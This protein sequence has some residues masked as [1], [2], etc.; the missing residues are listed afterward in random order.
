MTHQQQTSFEN[1]VGKGEIARNEQFLLFPQRFLLDQIILYPF[2]HIFDIISLFAAELQKPK[3][4]ISG[5]GLIFFLLFSFQT[6]HSR[7]TTK[8][9]FGHSTIVASHDE[10]MTFMLIVTVCVLFLCSVADGR[11]RVDIERLI[12]DKQV[13]YNM[14]VLPSANQSEPLLIRLA[15]ELKA[16][17]EFEEVNEQLSVIGTLLMGWN[18]ERMTWIPAEYGNTMHF[19]VT[20]ELFW[21]PTVILTNAYEEYQKIGDESYWPI[22]FAYNGDA[23][24][25]PGHVFTTICSADVKFYPW[26][27]QECSL[28][29]QVWGHFVSEVALQPSRD[30]V[31]INHYNGHGTWDFEG[32]KAFLKD[33]NLTISFTLLLNRK[34]TFV[35]VN[36]ILPIIFMGYLNT[37]VFLM[38]T[39]CGERTSYAITVLLALAVFLTLVGD[40]MPKSAR[41]IAY[42]SY[43]IMAVLVLSVIIILEIT[44]TMRVFYHSEGEDIPAH[45]AFLARFL[46]CKTCRKKSPTRPHHSVTGPTGE[47]SHCENIE[48]IRLHTI[49]GDSFTDMSSQQNGIPYW[50]GGYSAN[51]R[52]KDC[53]KNVVSW[54][55]V[56]YALDKIFFVTSF[57]AITVFTTLFLSMTIN[58]KVVL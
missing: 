47:G 54:E 6:G 21:T 2:V 53:V 36:L 24:Y 44:L 34:P 55:D 56:S 41:S 29:F 46:N 22:R 14:Y 15:F 11:N 17:R 26:D 12:A 20:N 28:E 1:I 10:K 45:L 42:L 33:D 5:K 35:V 51:R 18:D 27:K 37:I 19:I 39:S 48:D 52:E 9:N 7:K 57:I 32:S 16:I 58:S 38:P 25:Y 43:Y 3:I 13:N 23:A 49:G 4:G 40:N 50:N 30:T 8:Y 31:Y